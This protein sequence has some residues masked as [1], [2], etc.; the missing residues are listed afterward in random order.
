[1]SHLIKINFNNNMVDS[2]FVQ[3]GTG[4]QCVS[5]TWLTGVGHTPEVKAYADLTKFGTV[6]EALT[7][8]GTLYKALKEKIVGPLGPVLR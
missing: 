6:D 5:G 1:M 2:T 8:P 7:T 4:Y 3:C